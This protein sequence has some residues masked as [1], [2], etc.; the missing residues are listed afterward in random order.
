V[1]DR[2]TTFVRTLIAALAA[3]GVEHACVTPG[4]RSA[5]LSIALADSEIRDW[6]HHDERSAAFFALGIAKTTGRPVVVVTTSGTAAVELHPALVEASASQIP[7]IALTAD[8]PTDLYDVGAP[9]TIDQR[10]LFGTTVK[11]AHDLDVPNPTDFGPTHTAAL[12]ARLVSE[13]LGNPAGPVHLNVRFREPLL[14]ESDSVAEVPVPEVTRHQLVPDPQAISD[15]ATS[16]SGRSGL[17]V[18]GPITD[19]SSCAHVADLG[20]A[21]GWPI[22]SDP[23]SGLRSGGHPTT[24]VVGS[25][26]LA[27]AD[28]LAEA[29]PEVVIRIG[30]PPTSKA[31]R[32]WLGQ[33]AQIPQILIAP[34]GWPDPMASANLVLRSDVA[35]AATR[36]GEA[37]AAPQGWL[38]RWKQ[39]DGAAA[40]AALSAIEAT[41]FPS[42]PGVAAALSDALPNGSMLWAASSMPI[43]DIDSFYPVSERTVEIHGNR[44]ANGIDGFVSTALGAASVGRPAT[45][46][47]GDLSML[48]DVGALATAGRH[49]IPLTI[50]V[51]NNDGGGIFHFLPPSG[52]QHFERH[53]GTPHG[54]SFAPIAASFGVDSIAIDDRI[55]FAEVLG[56]PSQEPRLI[57][58]MTKR[59]TNVTI[60]RLI[61]EEVRAALAS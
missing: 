23:I 40:A 14:I 60:H 53:F 52:H 28:W 16:I 42:E 30:A 44:G 21:L 56:V 1:A 51:V 59:H 54:V 22:M 18:A 11:W 31:L 7:L 48:H 19:R 33:N 32:A 29:P 5:P 49:P 15:L 55:A 41:E 47:V 34:S 35:E 38:T 43:R 27:A 50:V 8:R 2:N 17:I 10:D 37:A 13:S 58:V 9:Q 24:A 20:I 12:G 57:E 45:S 25:D 3:S 61:A 4:S 46:L 39:A 26:L 6:S 36:L